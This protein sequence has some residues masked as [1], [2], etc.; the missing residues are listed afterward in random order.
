MYGTEEEEI[1]ESVGVAIHLGTEETGKIVLH[2]ERESGNLLY[3]KKILNEIKSKFAYAK[4]N[5]ESIQL[6]GPV[7]QY[8]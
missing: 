1:K 5:W 4:V 2:F 3:Y 8:D 7:G 6:K